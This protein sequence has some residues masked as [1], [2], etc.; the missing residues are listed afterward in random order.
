MFHEEYVSDG[1]LVVF[2]CTECDYHSLSLG[3]LHA[4]VET[5][6]GYTRFGIQLP[7]TSTSPGKADELMERTEVLRVEETSEISLA[8]VEGL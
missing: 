4:H 6:R 2:S 7:F 5:H 8:G 1:C 3:S